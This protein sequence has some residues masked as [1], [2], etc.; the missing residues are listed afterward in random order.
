MLK[1][2]QH[3]GALFYLA[4]PVQFYGGPR[5]HTV[6]LKINENNAVVRFLEKL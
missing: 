5:H 1:G 6:V 3:Q 4:A 2:F